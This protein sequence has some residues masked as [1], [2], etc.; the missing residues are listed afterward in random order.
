MKEKHHQLSATGD[1]T[2]LLGG[3]FAVVSLLPQ[4]RQFVAKLHT[5]FLDPVKIKCRM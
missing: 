3:C 2:C 4:F 5:D 1:N